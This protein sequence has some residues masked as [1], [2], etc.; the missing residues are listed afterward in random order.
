MRRAVILTSAILVA[1]T[2]IPST[3]RAQASQARGQSVAAGPV[4]WESN[5]AP[6]SRIAQMMAGRASN[7]TAADFPGVTGALYDVGKGRR[8]LLAQGGPWQGAST[9]GVAFFVDGGAGTFR[10]AGQITGS[11]SDGLPILVLPS[12]SGAYPAF[13]VT[14][15]E[16]IRFNPRLP[17]V[18]QRTGPKTFTVRYDTRM[19]TYAAARR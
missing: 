4:H 12:E 7:T 8:V 13:Q 17:M 16:V 3:V 18:D 6:A 14:T 2:A 5:T 1:C 19:G 11:H 15:I 9:S 10:N